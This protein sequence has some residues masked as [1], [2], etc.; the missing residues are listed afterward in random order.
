[1]SHN[2]CL[3]CL[4]C[5][6]PS[7]P[8]KP[9]SIPVSSRFSSE[10]FARYAT[11]HENALLQHVFPTL[12]QQTTSQHELLCSSTCH[13]LR[14][15]KNSNY[16]ISFLDCSLILQLSQASFRSSLKLLRSSTLSY[17]YLVSLTFSVYCSTTPTFSCET[18]YQHVLPSLQGFPRGLAERRLQQIS[19]DTADSPGL[20]LV[21]FYRG[22]LIRFSGTG[23]TSC[24]YR[25][26]EAVLSRPLKEPCPVDL[27]LRPS[28]V[29]CAH[30]HLVSSILTRVRE[31]S[32]LA[33][34][35]II[36]VWRNG[37]KPEETA[38]GC[39]R[40]K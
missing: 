10:I 16:L 22:V 33:R 36:P 20:C 17:L 3:F 40:A 28:C 27:C 21:W 23:S 5:P 30:R 7:F 6:I 2:L 34:R 12:C 1:M 32:R 14:P 35:L 25:Y 24:G 4:A 31:R 38:R 29:S 26:F 18:L 15:A 9:H 39:S 37:R 19:V 11:R 13:L 8:E